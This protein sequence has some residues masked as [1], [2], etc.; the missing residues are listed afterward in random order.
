MYSIASGCKRPSER[1]IGQYND[2]I[3]G[4]ASGEWVD[5][6]SQILKSA[7]KIWA[8]V[9]TNGWLVEDLAQTILRLSLHIAQLLKDT[10]RTVV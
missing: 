1:C 10:I 4:G 5:V 8:W 2:S 3:C 7:K 6:C 9:C